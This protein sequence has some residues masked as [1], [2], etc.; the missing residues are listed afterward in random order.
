[1]IFCGTL[2]TGCGRDDYLVWSPNG[3]QVAVLASDGL[4]LGDD[5]GNISP[6]ILPKANLFRW[7]PDS[8]HGLVVSTD[9]TTKWAAITDLLSAGER[10]KISRAA[11]TLWK[12]GS[13]SKWKAVDSDQLPVILVYLN[14]RYGIRSVK[15]KLSAYF[16][17]SYFSDAAVTISSLQT[18]D[19][20]ATTH[21]HGK[22]LWRTIQEI[23]DVRI[24]PSGKLVAVSIRNSF[25]YKIIV[26]PVAGGAPKTVAEAL[27]DFPDWSVDGKSLFFICY[28]PIDQT[29]TSGGLSDAQHPFIA[30]LDRREIADNSGAV[31]PKFAATQILAEVLASESSRVRCLA[32]GS[33]LFNSMQRTFPAVKA[34][35]RRGGLFRLSP[36]LQ[37]IENV[38]VVDALPDDSLASFEP[39][40]DGSKIALRGTKGEVAVL[41][42]PSGLVTALEKKRH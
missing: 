33:I 8:V 5:S 11:E 3:K 9:G 41:D 4:R 21:S 38:K 14:S 10:Q 40:Q 25:A 36:D 20:A 2:L 6:P 24:S 1:M 29:H 15:A 39:N 27:A 22:L 12:S 35:D 28:P 37:S 23:G 34:E 13:A 31:L 18:F 16:D 7:L 26:V 17:G 19:S 32:D 30:T 42:V